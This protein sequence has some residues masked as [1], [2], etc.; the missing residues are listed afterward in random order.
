MARTTPGGQAAQRAAPR[1]RKGCKDPDNP[2]LGAIK[3]NCSC[4]RPKGRLRADVPTITSAATAPAAAANSTPA[5]ASPPSPAAADTVAEALRVADEALRLEA[6]RSAVPASASAQDRLSSP[7][8]LRILPLFARTAPVAE[9]DAS[10][11]GSGVGD[12]QMLGGVNSPPGFPLS[13]QA[14]GT[15]HNNNSAHGDDGDDGETRAADMDIDLDEEADAGNAA[16]GVSSSSESA[17]GNK[18][19]TKEISDAEGASI[20]L[21]IDNAHAQLLKDKVKYQT[22]PEARARYLRRCVW[23]VARS[24]AMLGARTGTAVFFGFAQLEPGKH[25]LPH[26]VYADPVL[27]DPSRGSLHDMAAAMFKTFVKKTDF[28]RESQ[29]VNIVNQL[30]ERH[31]WQQKEMEYQDKIRQLQAR[32][33]AQDIAQASTVQAQDLLANAASTSNLASLAMVS[34][35]THTGVRERQEGNE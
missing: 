4:S 18:K 32:V 30:R 10:P 14:H 22:N 17:A 26:Y 21:D 19:K 12:E 1:C 3:A 34:S 16:D 23:R 35:D 27:C 7:P 8:S 24:V 29:R 6:A 20:W 31:E 5:A 28:Y 15:I 33:A 9:G 25:R 13:R 11:S 2:I